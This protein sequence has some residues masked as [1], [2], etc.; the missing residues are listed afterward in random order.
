MPQKRN[1]E[2]TFDDA[3]TAIAK[4]ERGAQSGTHLS[5][6]DCTALLVIIHKMIDAVDKK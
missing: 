4:L 2:P 1:K 3:L 6:R 5:K